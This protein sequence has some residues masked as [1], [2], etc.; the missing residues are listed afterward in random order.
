MKKI[1]TFFGNQSD[2]AINILS[3]NEFEIYSV[4]YPILSLQKTLSN[5]GEILTLDEIR[6]RGYKVSNHIWI[7]MLLKTIL[8]DKN[9]II[10]KDLWL[11]DLTDIIKPVYI[12]DE[13]D[14]LTVLIS[15]DLN[16]EIE[17]PV[18]NT[19]NKNEDDILQEILI[20]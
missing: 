11:N 16:E 13:Y 17:M 19:L 9:K 18:I 20:L 14:D 12:T 10:L 8:K 3:Q 7:N 4:Q 6:E 5:N 15:D 2:L 1:Y